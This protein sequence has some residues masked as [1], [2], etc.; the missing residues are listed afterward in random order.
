MRY[1]VTGGA[2]FIGSHLVDALVARDGGEIVVLDNLR[3][4]RTEFIA[5]HIQDGRVRFVEADIRDAEAVRRES[6][7]IDVVFHL[8]AQS[9]VIGAGKD[10]RYSS[11][12]NVNGTINVLEAALQEGVSR[13]V[14]TSSREVYG[15]PDTLP[16]SETAPLAPKNLYGASKVAGEMYCR[17]YQG[18]GLDVRYVRLGNVYGSRDRDR[19]IPIWLDR[20]A[21]G[22]DLELYGGSQV[23]DLIPVDFVVKALLR[24]AEAP[25]WTGPINIASGKGTPLIELAQQVLSLTGAETRTRFLPAREEEVIGFVADV[26]A[27][28]PRL[29]LIPPEP[30]AG[31]S[32]MVEA[33]R[34]SY[35]HAV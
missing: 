31:L 29:G 16:V 24:A 35:L 8:A 22:L 12:T 20:A 14:F 5:E 32:D 26:T 11:E 1:L 6:A 28:K 13:V 3:R 10:V 18:R 4:G 27:L 25:S 30:L 19:V 9:N 17:A 2:G 33:S 34:A 7:G 21:H 15:D 23:L